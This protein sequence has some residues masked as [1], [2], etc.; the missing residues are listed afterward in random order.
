MLAREVL[1]KERFVPCSVRQDLTENMNL[2]S[3]FV[4][5][6]VPLVVGP[7]LCPI[8]HLV[9]T[10]ASFCCQP[11]L[12]RMVIGQNAADTIEDEVADSEERTRMAK[13]GTQ[14]W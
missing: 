1:S 14:T 7:I 4:A 11:C 5:I 10:F 12:R 6:C 13:A 2:I 3:L 9:L 8:V